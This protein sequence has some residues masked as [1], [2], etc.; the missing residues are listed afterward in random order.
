MYGPTVLSAKAWIDCR[1]RRDQE[2]VPSR[3]IEK[4]AT[5][6]VR[7]PHRQ[8]P[9]P[10]LTM[11]RVQEGGAEQHGISAAFSTGSQAQ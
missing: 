6:R 1:T 8:N 11:A 2:R 9:A 5:T 10:L 4:L 7:L 3:A